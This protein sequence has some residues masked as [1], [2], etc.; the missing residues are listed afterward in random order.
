MLL[1]SVALASPAQGAPAAASSSPAGGEEQAL[2]DFRN[3][4]AAASSVEARDDL[5]RF[6][7]LSATDRQTLERYLTGE[8]S[9]W[10]IT[11]SP[12]ATTRVN[13]TTRVVTDGAARWIS[14][15]SDGH[16]ETPPARGATY[17]VH[18]SADETFT[19]VGITI[20][21]TRVWADYRTGSGIVTNLVDYGCQLV[22]NYD[23]FSKIKVS[24]QSGILSGGQATYKCSVLVERGVPTPWGQVNTT[25]RSAYQFMRVAGR[26]ISAHGWM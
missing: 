11:P 12:R 17:S 3:Q 7:S 10:A 4:L 2:D 21:K 22:S 6:D 9:P 1:V 23:P 18:S 26:G 5:A 24:R 14:T 15:V 8:T 16:P 20:S 25:T 13:G 19:L